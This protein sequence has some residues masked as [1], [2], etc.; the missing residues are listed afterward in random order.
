M[1]WSGAQAGLQ[2]HQ[3]WL[4]SIGFKEF[5]IARGISLCLALTSMTSESLAIKEQKQIILSKSASL[6]W[7]IKLTS[8]VQGRSPRKQEYFT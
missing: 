2:P 1:V 3:T 4:Y 7:F 8:L 6:G 5:I